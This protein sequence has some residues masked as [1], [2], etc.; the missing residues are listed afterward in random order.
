[1]PETIFDGIIRQE[2]VVHVFG[3]K[4]LAFNQFDFVEFNA[5]PSVYKT[6]CVSIFACVFKNRNDTLEWLTMLVAATP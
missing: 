3:A 1:L 5:P 2:I 4:I 6:N